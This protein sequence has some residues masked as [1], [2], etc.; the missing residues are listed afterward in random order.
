MKIIF[1]LLKSLLTIIVIS[2][3]VLFMFGWTNLPDERRLQVLQKL[4]E[5][6][7][8]D[9]IGFSQQIQRFA[10][11]PLPETDITL[12]NISMPLPVTEEVTFPENHLQ[13][14]DI[15]C[16]LPEQKATESINSNKIYQWEDE[17]GRTHFGDQTDHLAARDLST[18]YHSREHFFELKIEPINTPLPL[19]LS[20][21]ISVSI[22]KI[23]MVLS[24][25]LDINQLHQLVLNLKLF[26]EHKEFQTYLHAKAPALKVATGLYSARE[27]EAAVLMQTHEAHS[28]QVIRHESAHVIMANLYGLTPLWLNEG[29]AEYFEGLKITGFETTVYPNANW[30]RLLNEK[31]TSGSL[32]ISTYLALTPQQWQGENITQ[33]YAEA[34]SLVYFLLSNTQGKSLLA[35]YFKALS[36][37]RC[38]IPDSH[39]YFTQNYPGGLEQLNQDWQQWISQTDISPHRY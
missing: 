8:V 39:T 19:F 14:M 16:G 24:Q 15:D 10:G 9:I 32:S 7:P 36:Q 29:F 35:G 31:R 20:E 33:H 30:L 25:A 6:L 27:N 22:N 5:A 26:G 37:Y 38:L 18:Q 11:I 13:A 1:R 4:D 12:Q 21:K 28:L 17:Q 2:A 23:F 34:W 3:F